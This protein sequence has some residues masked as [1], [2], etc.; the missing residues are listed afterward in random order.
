MIYLSLI[1]H[2]HST[3][4]KTRDEELNLEAHLVRTT[5]LIS[6]LTHTHTARQ[7]RQEM[8]S[9]VR[10][11]SIKSAPSDAGNWVGRGVAMGVVSTTE[12][13]ETWRRWERGDDFG[14]NPSNDGSRERERQRERERERERFKKVGEGS[15]DKRNKCSSEKEH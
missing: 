2:T 14:L 8:K 13:A 6:Y 1:S 11:T 3:T 7:L 10:T 4:A 15:C 12:V 9:L 5:Q